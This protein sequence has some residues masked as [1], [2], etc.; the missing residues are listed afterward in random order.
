MAKDIQRPGIGESLQEHFRLTGSIQ[1]GLEEFVSPTVLVADLSQAAVPP[2]RRHCS[3]TVRVN[4]QAAEVFQGLFLVPP[5]VIADITSISFNAA[6][7]QIEMGF[8]PSFVAPPVTPAAPVF[9]DQR[10]AELAGPPIP[11]SR[12]LTG[13]DAGGV[14]VPA[15]ELTVD[16]NQNLQNVIHPVGWLIGTGQ[17]AQDPVSGAPISFGTL[18]MASD[19]VNTAVTC[20]MQWDE[21]LIV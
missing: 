19:I 21:Y 6:R 18:E 14:V 20:I 12:F 15:F 10:V 17:S 3:L 13:T 5:G 7:M 1:L 8:R 9:T 2:L 16:S 11:S 4:A